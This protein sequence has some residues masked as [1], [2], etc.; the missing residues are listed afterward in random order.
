MSDDKTPKDNLDPATLMSLLKEKAKELRKT[1]TKL[2]KLEEKFVEMHKKEKLL[3]KD[4]QTFVEF[5]YL[6]FPE[7]FMKE[8][9]LPDDSLGLYDIDH[10]KQ[11]WLHLKSKQEAQTYKDNLQINDDF[12]AMKRKLSSVEESC[13]ELEELKIRNAELEAQLMRDAREVIALKERQAE[14]ERTSVDVQKV[15]EER[16]R[17]REKVKRLEAE[18][19]E[20]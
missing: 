5:M 10:I 2:N 11:F 9:L 19:S 20:Q 12:E 6:V 14:L 8:V 18:H 3:L 7:D 4:R 16:D 15:T 17:L 1:Q 13:L